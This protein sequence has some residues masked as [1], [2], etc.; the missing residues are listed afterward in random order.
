M[1]NRNIMVIHYDYDY[2]N[3]YYNYSDDQD[4]NDSDYYSDAYENSYRY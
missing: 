2:S 1:I 3:G 4:H